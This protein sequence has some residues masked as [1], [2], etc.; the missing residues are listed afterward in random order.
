MVIPNALDSTYFKPT[1]KENYLPKKKDR[2]RIIVLCR[3]CYKKGMDLLIQILPVICK[4]YPL[5]EFYIAG[6]GNK[7]SLIQ[8]IIKE[9]KIEK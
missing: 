6:D 7:K 8:E 3:L 2:I 9:Y 4:K 1:I 5:V